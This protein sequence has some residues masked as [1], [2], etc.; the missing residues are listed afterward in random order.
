VSGLRSALD[1]GGFDFRNNRA[2][3]QSEIAESEIMDRLE[4]MSIFVAVVD[5]G[6]L[7]AAARA[8]GRSP[9]TV[10]RAI[11][12]LEARLGER[13]LHRNARTLRLTD[14]GERHLAVY[15]N[16][17][18]ELDDAERNGA[19][20]GVLAGTIGITAPEL[21]GRLKVMPV[22]EEFLAGHP[23]VR[24]RMLLLDR[25]VNLVE[26]GVDIAVRLA[27]L[28]DSG[29][30]AVRLGEVRKLVCAA[31]AYLERSGVPDSPA[32]LPRHICLGE[33]EANERELWRFVDRASPR[34]RALSVVIEPRIAL[35]GAGAS[36]DAALRGSGICRA[37]SYQVV[38]HLAAGRLVALLPGFEPEPI[39]VHLVFHPIP[40]RNAVLRAFV[41]HATPRL[42]AELAAIA[43]R[44]P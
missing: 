3:W 21:F 5:A 20:A 6:S 37:L 24:A 36:I 4:A 13:L 38:D 35:N 11:M 39:P 9:A 2:G 31:P 15:R 27:P 41:D 23:A 33:E 32:G 10:T 18:A 30:V 22:L 28:P 12:M 43:A 29:V 16:V 40:R 17:L 44:M 19:G 42:R 8:L 7:A 14:S 25:L 1:V 34:N 26:E